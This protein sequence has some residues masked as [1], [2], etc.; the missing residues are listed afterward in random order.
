MP[1]NV[2]HTENHK[3]KVT[4]FLQKLYSH[5]NKVLQNIATEK[6]Q[7]FGVVKIKCNKVDD[8]NYNFLVMTSFHKIII[9]RTHVHPCTHTHK[10]KN[11]QYT[12]TY[13]NQITNMHPHISTQSK[14]L[15]DIGYESLQN[16]CPLKP[17]LVDDLQSWT[18][19]LAYFLPYKD[20]KRR[21]WQ[22]LITDWK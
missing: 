10:P 4:L 15:L 22:Q 12:M 20:I 9:M 8:D 7:K 18:L 14:S 3:I 6:S 1:K 19:A 17:L 16:W 21:H 5:K 11:N 13:Q 2:Q